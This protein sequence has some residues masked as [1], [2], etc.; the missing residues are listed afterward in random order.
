VLDLLD[1]IEDLEA[2]LRAGGAGVRGPGEPTARGEQR[3]I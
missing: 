1:R 3:W 2:A